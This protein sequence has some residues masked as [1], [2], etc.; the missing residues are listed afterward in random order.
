MSEQILLLLDKVQA[1]EDEIHGVTRIQVITE[2]CPPSDNE[3]NVPGPMDMPTGTKKE[4]LESMFDFAAGRF[5]SA[6]NHT[7]DDEPY[8][9]GYKNAIECALRILEEDE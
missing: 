5:L 9:R 6:A 7:D 2:A 1:L 4:R 3:P 8:W